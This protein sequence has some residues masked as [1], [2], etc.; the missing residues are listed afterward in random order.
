MDAESPIDWPRRLSGKTF[1]YIFR[2]ATAHLIGE[3][4]TLSEARL[5]QIRIH[6]GA[7]T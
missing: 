2:A 6:L 3:L 7:T 4:F 1:D 5:H